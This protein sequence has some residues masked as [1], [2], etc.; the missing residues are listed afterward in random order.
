MPEPPVHPVESWVLLSRRYYGALCRE[1]AD[2]EWSAHWSARYEAAADNLLE[3][4]AL[5]RE[6]T[7]HLARGRRFWPDARLARTQR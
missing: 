2:W 4:Q 5:D 1:C 3:R 6:R 7:A